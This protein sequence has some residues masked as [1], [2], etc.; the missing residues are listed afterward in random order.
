MMLSHLELAMSFHLQRVQLWHR[1]SDGPP[2]IACNRSANP[3]F[4]ILEEF[5]Q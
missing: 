2:D 3:N 1:R 5:L 4:V